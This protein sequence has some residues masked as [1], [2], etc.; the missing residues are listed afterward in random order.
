MSKLIITVAPTGSIYTKSDTPYIPLTPSEIAKDVKECHDAGASIVHIHARDKSGNKTH[1]FVRYAET[2]EKIKELCP[3]MIIQISTGG[4][5]GKDYDSRTQGL[6]LNPESASLTPGSVNFEEMVYQNAP[7][8]IERL[9]KEMKERQIKPEL[10]IYDINMIQQA[11][12]LKEKGLLKD[13]LFFNFIMGFKNCQPATF[14]Q[15]A[16]LLNTIPKDSL[17]SITGVGKSQMF[18]IFQGVSLG[19]HVR[20]GLE[21]NIFYRNGRFGKNVH[22][23]ERTVK[24]AREFGREIA[25]PDEARKILKIKR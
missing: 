19:G 3:K 16:Y 21:D 12:E 18:T 13:P 5:A 14:N 1:D 8:F 15:L 25:S 10:E 2:V 4:R 24:I 22:F 23:V 17:W 6:K 7:D 11:I 9:A 20:V